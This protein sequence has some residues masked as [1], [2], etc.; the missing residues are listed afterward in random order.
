M[1]DIW[2][3]ILAAGE[4]R[5]MGFPKMLLSFKGRTMIETVIDN[6]LRSYIK[7]VIVVL[8]A[9]KEAIAPKLAGLPVKSCFNERYKDGML[10]SVKC[11]FENLPSGYRAAI[12]F[13]GDQPMISPDTIDSVIDGYIVSGKGLV[14]PSYLK[15][16]G[17]PLLIDKKYHD[18]ISMLNPAIGLHALQDRFADD[19]LMVPTNDQGILHDIDT[20]EEY[21]YWN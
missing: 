19:V 1:K 6:V 10:S 21:L 7:Q 8:G 17:H 12:V 16:S 11:G 9:G 20:Y 3:I 4:S 13:Q 5:R 14:M 15:K 2:A 18:E